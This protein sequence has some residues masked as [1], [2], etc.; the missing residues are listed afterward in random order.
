MPGWMKPANVAKR[1]EPSKKGSGG[2]SDMQRATEK[3]ISEGKPFGMKLL[4]KK[5]EPPA[6]RA[7]RYAPKAAR[8][9]N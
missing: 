6:S 2:Y 7:N 1:D 9:G 8:R 5:P 3:A 4:G